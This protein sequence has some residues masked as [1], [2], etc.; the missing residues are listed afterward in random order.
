MDIIPFQRRTSLGP[1]GASSPPPWLVSEA[2]GVAA[3]VGSIVLAP[4]MA[5][6]ADLQGIGRLG[7]GVCSRVAWRVLA[8]AGG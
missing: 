5:W 7:T 1:S 2:S 4:I 8:G 6:L 3:R